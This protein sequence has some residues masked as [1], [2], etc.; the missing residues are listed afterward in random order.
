MDHPWQGKAG[1]YASA[2]TGNADCDMLRRHRNRNWIDHPH[3]VGDLSWTPPGYGSAIA[4]QDDDRQQQ[5][6]VKADAH[7]H[8]S[9][10]R[11][12]GE[13]KGAK[14]DGWAPDGARPEYI[15]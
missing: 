5:K 6:A 14:L 9:K 1:R 2:I 10:A 12:L 3:N 11:I 15:G 13:R 8:L 7:K 4:Q